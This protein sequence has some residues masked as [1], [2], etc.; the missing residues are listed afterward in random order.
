MLFLCCNISS[1][2]ILIIKND[3]RNFGYMCACAREIYMCDLNDLIYIYTYQS[4]LDQLRKRSKKRNQ[5]KSV[6][7]K[8]HYFNDLINLVSID[9]GD[10]LSTCDAPVG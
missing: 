10:L 1:S 9:V 7:I 5:S 6:I 3:L 2:S 8:N 4:L